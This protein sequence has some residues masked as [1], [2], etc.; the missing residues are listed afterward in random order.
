MLSR[1]DN[2]LLCKVGP[3]TPGGAFIRQYW[4]PA[5]TSSE[6]PERDGAP[7]RLRLLGENLIAFRDTSGHVGL[8]QGACP[9]R[10]ASLFFAR[11]EENGLRCVYHGWKF[12]VTGKCVDMPLEPPESD[13]KD[14]VRATAYPTREQGGIVWAYMG[15]R[16]T[17]PPLPDLEAINLGNVK[18]TLAM[19][20]CNWVQAMEADLDT[21]HVGFLHWGSARLQDAR[22]GSFAYYAIKDPSPRY[23]VVDTEYGAL[24]GAYRPAEEDSYY[25]RIGAFL[26][27]FYT[28]VPVGVLGLQ[29]GVRCYVPLDDGHTMVWSIEPPPEQAGAGRGAGRAGVEFADGKLPGYESEYLPNTS[30]WLGRWRYVQNRQNDY[31]IDRALQ[32]RSSYTGIIG[33]SAQDQGISESMGAISDKTQEHLGTSDIMIA[34]CRQRLLRAMR[35]LRNSGTVP[36][37]VDNPEIYRVRSGGALLP[38]EA[39]WLEATA[40]RRQAYTEHPELP[41]QA[42]GF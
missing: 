36:A 21:G 25:W 16:T 38:R 23:R 37:G 28:M 15:E 2:E 1:E 41:E 12:D 4:L 6:L 29:I 19:R 13:Y 8:I 3:E 5:L 20:E 7:M 11:N 33:A 35:A 26:F 40:K 39:D 31:L 18:S 9:H 24:Y 34:R 14:K 17:P 32:R 10:C 30:D 27:P 22:P 42:A